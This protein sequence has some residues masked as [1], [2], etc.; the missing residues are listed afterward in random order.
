MGNML[1]D[2]FKQ[3]RKSHGPMSWCCCGVVEVW[4]NEL[5]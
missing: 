5:I 2:V 3:E 4:L 1:R